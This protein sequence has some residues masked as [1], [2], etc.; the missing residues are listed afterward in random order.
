MTQKLLFLFIFSL[1]LG[2]SFTGSAQEKH[3][4]KVVNDTAVYKERY[5]LRIG[6]D[7][8][9]PARGFL[10]KKYSGLELG[11]DYRFNE[12]FY[13]AIEIGYENFEYD[14]NYFSAKSQGSYAKL[15]VNYNAYKNWI[16]LQNELYAGLRYGF[17]SF[18]EELHNFTIYDK[19]QYF[20]PDYREDSQKFSSLSGHWLE[21]QLGIK[22][23]IMHNVFLGLHVELKRLISSKNPDN[24]ESLWIPGFNRHYDG[25]EFGIGWGYSISYL[26]PIYTKERKEV[27]K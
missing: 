1:L 17:S 4:V 14:E 11:A 6:I 9:R 21:L 2:S 13:P 15:G 16:G 20:P 19:D 3:G 24:F 27:R 25:S 10:D 7:L 5:G 18:S 12:R 23:E 26:L 22:A 8:S